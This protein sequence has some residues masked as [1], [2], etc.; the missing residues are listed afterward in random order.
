MNTIF[1]AHSSSHFYANEL[2]IGRFEQDGET[3]ENISA[4]EKGN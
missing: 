4:L 1:V 3:E 2:E